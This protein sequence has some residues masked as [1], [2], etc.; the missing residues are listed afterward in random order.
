M[1]QTPAS[2]RH[3]ASADKCKALLQH[4]LPTKS[5]ISVPTVYQGIT[6][7][8]DCRAA[9]ARWLL[10]PMPVA[11]GEALREPEASVIANDNDMQFLHGHGYF[12]LSN[13]Q[14]NLIPRATA[15][16]STPEGKD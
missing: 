9:L 6:G 10:E 7:F 1:T 2:A 14:K 15:Y 5:S 3:A 4:Q 16:V 12:Y 11:A 13:V 8:I